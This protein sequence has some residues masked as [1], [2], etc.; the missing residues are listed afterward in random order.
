MLPSR[1]DMCHLC[2]KIG[3]WR[4]REGREN[5]KFSRGLILWPTTI[6]KTYRL[7]LLYSRCVTMCCVKFYL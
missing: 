6:G 4:D 1:Y 2:R 7:H 5:T 3:M